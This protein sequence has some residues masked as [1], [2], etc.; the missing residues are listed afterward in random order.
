[1]GE[2]VTEDLNS[3]EESED[4]CRV[5]SRS[6]AGQPPARRSTASSKNSAMRS[7][8]A[9]HIA[10]KTLGLARK[11]S[12]LTVHELAILAN[13][14]PDLY[15]EVVKNEANARRLAWVGLT[16]QVLGHLSGLAALFMLI[17]VAWHFIDLGHPV[18]ATSIICSGAVSI[19]AVVVTG[20][21]A[22]RQS[23]AADNDNSRPDT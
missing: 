17:L 6:T 14:A 7:A 11:T 19:V 13:D 3:S 2:P 1:V 5:S 21:L 22:K 15:R 9:N 16:T 4:Q 20:R 23:S 12:D 10:G 18:E 8:S